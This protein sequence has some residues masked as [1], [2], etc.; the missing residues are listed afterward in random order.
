MGKTL[1]ASGKARAASGRPHEAPSPIQ[2]LWRSY[3]LPFRD[4]LHVA[5]G[6]SYDAVIDPAAPSGWRVRDPFDLA[7]VLAAEP[8]RTSEVDG[9]RALPL[10]DGGV[11][12]GGEG[13]HGSEGF[14]ARL[15]GE[16]SLAWALC[17]RDS[18]P[19]TEIH[20]EHGTGDQATGRAAGRTVGRTAGRAV[21]RST[22]GVSIS[23]DIAD[24]TCG[25]A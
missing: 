15:T 4:A 12:W 19:F 2:C 10:A 21:F 24:P 5:D 11:L 22:S 14:C 25:A 3:E 13:S 17:F 18:N 8:D 16:L 1:A 20:L 9:L 6:W 23:V 7:S